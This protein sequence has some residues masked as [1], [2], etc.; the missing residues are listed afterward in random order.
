MLIKKSYSSLKFS[1]GGNLLKFLKINII[2]YRLNR[3]N[4]NLQM[5]K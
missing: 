3:V 2:T 5:I 4:V 1:Q